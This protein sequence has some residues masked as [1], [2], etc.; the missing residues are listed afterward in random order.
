MR[1]WLVWWSVIEPLRE[2]CARQASFLW[3]AMTTAG[4]C[5]RGDLLGVS[6]I[7][8]TLGLAGR[9]YDRLLDFFHSP[10]VD[11]DRL[12]RKWTQQAMGLFPAYRYAGR[13]V[14]LGDGI[15][16]PKSGRKMPAVKLL[17]QESEGNTK[18]RYIMGH[19][20]QV[21]SMLVAAAGSFFAVPLAGRIHQGVKFTNRDHRTLPVK[22]ASLL[23]AISIGAPFYLVADAA[24]ACRSL[25]RRL[26]D[27]QPSYLATPA[28]R[29][30]LCASAAVRWTAK[31]RSSQAL[32]SEDQTVVA[33]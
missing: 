20:V 33:V 24:F 10:A 28:Q 26:V 9:C 19:S 29:R 5:A 32:W 30:C 25:A 22:F 4:I 7:V 15:K 12:S 14:L 2:V 18:P 1:L 16:I 11:P 23:D 8:R 21:V 17:Y 6:S 13:P 27:W 3:L 31:T